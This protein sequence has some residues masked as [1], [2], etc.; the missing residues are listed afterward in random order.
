MKTA[1]LTMDNFTQ[2]MFQPE[3]EIDKKIIELL[4]ERIPKTIYWET[5]DWSWEIV[6]SIH[7]WQ[8]SECQWWRGREYKYG[9]IMLKFDNS[10]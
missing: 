8:F 5:S 10:K 6:A 7:K 2:I 3:T 1:I 4:E 9:A